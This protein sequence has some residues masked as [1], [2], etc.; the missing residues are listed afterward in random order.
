MEVDLAWDRDPSTG[1]EET[2]VGIEQF[3]GKESVEEQAL[4][5][6][7]DVAEDEVEKA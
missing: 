4:P 6:G 3:R 5:A 2:G 7:I 1:T